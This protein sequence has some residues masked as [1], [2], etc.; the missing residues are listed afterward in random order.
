MRMKRDGDEEATVLRWLLVK[1]S[2]FLVLTSKLEFNTRFWRRILVF[3]FLFC[4]IPLIPIMLTVSL[5]PQLIK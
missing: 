1:T 4:S 3:M 2:V 5:A